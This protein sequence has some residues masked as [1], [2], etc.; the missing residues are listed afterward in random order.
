MLLPAPLPPSQGVLRAGPGLSGPGPPAPRQRHGRD[1]AGAD[2][3]VPDGARGRREQHLLLQP[4]GWV[5]ASEPPPA[6]TPGA[7]L[8]RGAHSRAAGEGRGLASPLQKRSRPHLPLSPPQTPPKGDLGRTMY[9]FS[10]RIPPYYTLLVRSLS[11]LEGIALA[12]DPNYKV[13]PR[14]AELLA[15]VSRGEGREGGAARGL[16]VLEG[17]ALASDPKLQSGEGPAAAQV[18]LVSACQGQSRRSSTPMLLVASLVL[19]PARSPP[20]PVQTPSGAGRGV[21]LDQPPPADAAVARAARH[22]AAAA[23]QGGRLQV[24]GGGGL[25]EDGAEYCGG[26]RRAA[27]QARAQTSP[28]APHHV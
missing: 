13:G 20:C 2:G 17:I 6:G 21:P 8:L 7:N 22:A 12:S 14:R 24:G 25:G 18:G 23:L 19:T 27:L 4:V 16:G 26:G 5:A 11:V 9:R 3:G 10:F 1:R 15:R 28:A